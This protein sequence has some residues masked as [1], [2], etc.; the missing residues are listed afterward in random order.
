MTEETI[1]AEEYPK[2]RALTRTDRKKLSELI[3]AFADR[4]GNIELTKML[5]ARKSDDVKKDDA[6]SD[7]GNEVDTEVNTDQVFDLV[8]SVMAGLFKWVEADVTAWFMD[9]IG[10]TDKEIYDNMPFDIEVHIIDEL[11]KQK[12]F[13]NF[14]SRASELYK[15]ARGLIG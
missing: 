1:N 11:L 12:G 9:V 8:K 2:V 6:K 5:P 4:S 7:D 15:K 13:S 3:K 14:F 10:V